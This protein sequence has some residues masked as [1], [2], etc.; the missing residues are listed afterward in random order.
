MLLVH[1][2]LLRAVASSSSWRCS[3]SPFA[4][5]IKRVLSAAVLLCQWGA[6]PRSNSGGDGKWRMRRWLPKGPQS[7]RSEL[8][9][10]EVAHPSY[11]AGGQ[12]CWSVGYVK[13]LTKAADGMRLPVGKVARV[14]EV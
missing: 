1:V 7:R 11:A 6:L 14:F 8:A 5:V 9:Y 13:P 2:V 4:G 12:G 10:V 3:V